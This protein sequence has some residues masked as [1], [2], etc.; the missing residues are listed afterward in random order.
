MFRIRLPAPAPSQ[1]GEF[2]GLTH[3]IPSYFFSKFFDLTFKVVTITIKLYYI[4]MYIQYIGMYISTY[5]TWYGAIYL[6]EDCM[7]GKLAKLSQYN[8]RQWLIKRNTVVF[9]WLKL[10]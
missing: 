2:H 7:L 4:G 3:Y 10:K 8:T 5:G 1:T 6:L 9:K